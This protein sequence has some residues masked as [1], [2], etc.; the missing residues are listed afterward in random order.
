MHPLNPH[1]LLMIREAKRNDR[2]SLKRMNR[3]F[4]LWSALDRN[5]VC[6]GHIVDFLLVIIQAYELTTL[7]EFAR[8]TQEDQIW[9]CGEPIAGFQSKT[10][11]RVCRWALSKLRCTAV[12]K[13]AGWK[14]PLR[15]KT[16]LK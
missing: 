5:Y 9:K 11:E 15:F 2:A 3:I 7:S 10:N 1:Q 16:N 8:D 12:Y 4:G 13:F 14:S 6:E